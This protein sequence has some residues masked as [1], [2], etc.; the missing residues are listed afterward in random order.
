MKLGQTLYVVVGRRACEGLAVAGQRQAG[1]AGGECRQGGEGRTDVAGE[2]A[3]ESQRTEAERVTPRCARPAAAMA[4]PRARPSVRGN[5][6]GP[7]PPRSLYWAR[8]F[9]PRESSRRGASVLH[10]VDDLGEEESHFGRDRAPRVSLLDE[11]EALVHGG[12]SELTVEQDDVIGVDLGAGRELQS[13]ASPF[14]AATAVAACRTTS[15]GM[16][17]ASR[18]RVARVAS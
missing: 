18:S 17:T 8:V 11:V 5:I 7:G 2:R 9:L 4:G 10:G 14:R 1:V 3:R 6:I 16:N 15:D 13:S 12:E